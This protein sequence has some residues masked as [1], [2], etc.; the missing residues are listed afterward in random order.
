MARTER[1]ETRREGIGGQGGLEDSKVGEYFFLPTGQRKGGMCQ[2]S[3]SSQRYPLPDISHLPWPLQPK[4]GDHCGRKPLLLGHEVSSSSLPGEGSHSNLQ[5]YL[6]PRPRSD[7]FRCPEGEFITW[8]TMVMGLELGAS[9]ASIETRELIRYTH[10]ICVRLRRACFN[11]PQ[12]TNLYS[13]KDIAPCDSIILHDVCFYISN[14]TLHDKV[15]TCD[16]R[17][18]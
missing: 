14:L 12:F 7:T 3:H 10:Y 4:V 5:E 18:G 11:V 8:P 2:Q 17:H 15:C 6:T 16:V 13:G 1:R 9:I